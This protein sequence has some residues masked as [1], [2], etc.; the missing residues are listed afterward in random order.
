MGCTGSKLVAAE[1]NAENNPQQA[2]FKNQMGGDT[3]P[4]KKPRQARL[5][6]AGGYSQYENMNQGGQ[7]FDNESG[8]N[9]LSPGVPSGVAIHYAYLSQRGHYPDQPNK[10]NQDAVLIRENVNGVPGQHLLGVLDGH[11]ETGAE[12]AQ[13]AKAKLPLILSG[14]TTLPTDPPS[15]M[16]AA[17]VSTNDQLHKAPIDDTL[18]GTTVCLALLQDRILY[19][20]NVGDS[21]AVLAQKPFKKPA[22]AADTDAVEGEKEEEKK[23]SATTDN[24]TTSNLIALELTA[25]QTPFR[26][27]EC[28]RVQ[29][30]G[31]RVMTLDQMEGLKERGVRCWTNEADCDGDP[32]RLWS[33]TG[34]YPGTAFTRSVGDS[35]AESIG[36]FAEPEITKIEI[37]DDMPFLILASDGIWEFISSQKAVDIV[38]ECN[39]PAEA[40]QALVSTAYKAWLK[41]ETR[42]DDISVAVMFFSSAEDRGRG[43]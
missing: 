41:K 32:P 30:A 6:L 35:V 4:L 42:T 24:D 5:S 9:H 16:H 33:P 17:L 18:S 20:A 13:F 39:D 31:A 38:A 12:C 11:G 34:T 25:D 7:A 23:A 28:E 14:D 36:V 10:A 15:A 26:E 1:P 43:I 29:H 22:T 40:A 27:D 37:T 19:V 8:R 21:R 2:S 3:A